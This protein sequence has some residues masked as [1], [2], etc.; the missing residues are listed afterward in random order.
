MVVICIFY[1]EIV[2]RV[3]DGD[4]IVNNSGSS[5][6]GGSNGSNGSNRSNGS[7]RSS[8]SGGSGGSRRVRLWLGGWLWLRGWLWLGLWLRIRLWGWLWLRIRGS[9]RFC[10][11]FLYHKAPYVIRFCTRQCIS[12]A[13]NHFYL[14]DALSSLF[15]EMSVRCA[16]RNIR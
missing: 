5:G 12:Q 7:C 3:R 4:T 6:S 10:R 2:L 15:A 11:V 9:F 16:Y 14:D 13:I 1:F 8:G